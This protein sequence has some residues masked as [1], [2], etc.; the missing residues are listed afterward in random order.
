MAIISLLISAILI[1]ISWRIIL[2]ALKKHKRNVKIKELIKLKEF[3]ESPVPSFYH[4]Q[5][6]DS[7]PL[8]AI[9]ARLQHKL[10]HKFLDPYRPMSE[11]MDKDIVKIVDK[12]IGTLEFEP[13]NPIEAALLAIRAIIFKE[14][15]HP[16]VKDL[17]LGLFK[18][19]PLYEIYNITVYSIKTFCNR[20]I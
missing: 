6:Y 8:C 19:D 17:G 3:K 2:E 10:G 11:D 9:L 5:K 16:I 7:R 4:Q 14:F 12:S 15:D 13:A 1:Y 20:N 18:D